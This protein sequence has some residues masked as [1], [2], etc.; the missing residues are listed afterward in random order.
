MD[1]PYEDEVSITH[2]RANLEFREAWS[3]I[4]SG[5]KFEILTLGCY[6][7]ECVTIALVSS[8]PT[9]P[10]EPKIKICGREIGIRLEGAPLARSEPLLIVHSR[11]SIELHGKSFEIP[12]AEGELPSF[13]SLVNLE[14]ELQ[15]IGLDVRGKILHKGRV[16]V[17][18]LS[19]PTKGILETKGVA[20]DLTP[21]SYLLAVPGKGRLLIEGEEL[22]LP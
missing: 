12:H 2:L 15:E 7:G 4:L 20:L 1:L 9:L 14:E 16:S 3:R 11:C 19:L 18:L 6:E 17:Y 5:Y 22:L 10:P 8:L 13:L 21:G